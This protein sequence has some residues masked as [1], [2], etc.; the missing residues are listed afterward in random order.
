MGK[1]S[2]QAEGKKMTFQEV[3]DE[4]FNGASEATHDKLHAWAHPLDFGRASL[5][6]LAYIAWKLHEIERKTPPVGGP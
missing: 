1:L 4:I 3:L 5:T 6:V 2:R